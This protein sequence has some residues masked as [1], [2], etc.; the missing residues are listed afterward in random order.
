MAKIFLI[1]TPLSPT[2]GSAFLNRELIGS[3]DYFVVENIRTARRFIAG[4]KLERKI[5]QMEFVELSEHT[6]PGDVEQMLQPI[7]SQGRSCGVM[8]EAGLPC[9]ADPGSLLVSAAHRAGV[10]V[11]PLVGGSSIMLALMCSGASGQNF[12]FNGYLPIKPDA[13]AVAI[14]KFERLAIGGQ[15][16]I[17]IETPYRNMS[18]FADFLKNCGANQMLCVACDLTDA[19]SLVISKKI[20]AWQSSPLPAIE[21]RPTIFILF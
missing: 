16:Q 11:V 20:G 21:K 18:L 17:F 6:S 14:K 15:T 7:V 19:N 4:L 12:A 13:R 8:S 1:P 10:Q 5:D 2:D 3:L 9:V